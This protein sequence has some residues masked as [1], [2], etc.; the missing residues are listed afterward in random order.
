MTDSFKF[1][2]N[3]PVRRVSDTQIVNS[4]ETFRS[5]HGD[6][7]FTTSEYD[8]WDERICTSALSQSV[9]EDGVRR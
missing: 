5:Q 7:A 2:L 9:L 6:K 3:A 1:D 4:L 8:K